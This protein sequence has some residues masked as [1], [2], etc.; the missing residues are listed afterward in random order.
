[1][2]SDNDTSRLNCGKSDTWDKIGCAGELAANEA[3]DFIECI[4]GVDFDCLEQISTEAADCASG[5]E[6][7]IEVG[8]DCLHFEESFDFAQELALDNN[9]INM[10]LDGTMNI[11]VGL[12]L[13]IDP[14][15]WNFKVKTKATVRNDLSLW[16]EAK[17]KEEYSEEKELTRRITLLRK[18]RIEWGQFNADWYHSV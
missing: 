14:A 16:L 6:C 5:G 12:D 9:Y 17:Q 13:V 7:I 4:S 2:R 15:R 1:M 11:D 18:V 8:G 3:I 10:R